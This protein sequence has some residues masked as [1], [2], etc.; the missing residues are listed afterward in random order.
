MNGQIYVTEWTYIV[1][2]DTCDWAC[3]VHF[4]NSTVRNVVLRATLQSVFF[5]DPQVLVK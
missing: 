3:V 2:Q 5:S 1:W 4:I